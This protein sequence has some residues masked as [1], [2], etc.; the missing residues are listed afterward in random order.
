M[1]LGPAG[2]GGVSMVLGSDLLT[3]RFKTHATE[4]VAS[5]HL[6]EASKPITH[7]EA[8]DL[9]L[10]A[11]L[12]G[13]SALAVCL[14]SG[15]KMVGYDLVKTEDVLSLA[16]GS[17]SSDV[18]LSAKDVEVGALSLLRF[19]QDSCVR[20]GSYLL[21]R[22]GG[23]D[24]T[25]RLF[26]LSGSTLSPGKLEFMA[27]SAANA[28]SSSRAPTGTT[29]EASSAASA[30]L[31]HLLAAPEAWAVNLAT[32]ALEYAQVVLG[33]AQSLQQESTIVLTTKEEAPANV[34]PKTTSSQRIHLLLLRRRLLQESID[35]MTTQDKNATFVD[36]LD[37][38]NPR[39]SS[40]STK[41]SQLLCA[42]HCQI[43]SAYLSIADELELDTTDVPSSVFEGMST[44]AKESSSSSSD[45]DSLRD[46][47]RIHVLTALNEAAK[48]LVLS[49]R[50]NRLQNDTVM[51]ATNDTLP[52]LYPDEKVL[53]IDLSSAAHRIVS[54]LLSEHEPINRAAA[55]MQDAELAF[56][57]IE[58]ILRLHHERHDSITE[59]PSI[60][61]SL[62]A[63]MLG[64]TVYWITRI[65]LSASASHTPIVSDSLVAS[66][67]ALS[68][69]GKPHSQAFVIQLHDQSLR[70]NKAMNSLSAQL[71]LKA[72]LLDFAM[73]R[74][75]GS[76][77]TSTQLS[78]V[79]LLLYDASSLLSQASS[80]LSPSPSSSSLSASS[81]K[82]A[83]H[84]IKEGSLT[85]NLLRE[86]K[87]RLGNEL[88]S[89]GRTHVS[90][91]SLPAA[92][93]CFSRAV[94]VFDDVR[95]LTNKSIAMTNVSS[96]L[97]TLGA[98]GAR[99]NTATVLIE[100]EDTERDESCQFSLYRNASSLANAF[101]DG[102]EERIIESSKPI[103]ERV[104]KMTLTTLTPTTM[105]NE[106][107]ETIVSTS[108]TP[109]SATLLQKAL[110]VAI[111]AL[112]MAKEAVRAAKGDSLAT[113]AST[114]AFEMALHGTSQSALVF[115]ALLSQEMRVVSPP[116]LS[117]E[118]LTPVSLNDYSLALFNLASK[119]ISQS[120][121]G[122]LL[123][124]LAS[125]KLQLSLHLTRLARLLHQ[126][127]PQSENFTETRS[128]ALSALSDAASA[129]LKCSE[130]SDRAFSCHCYVEKAK[131]LC[132]LKGQ[133][134]EDEEKIFHR[135]KLAVCAILSCSLPL[136]SVVSFTNKKDLSDIYESVLQAASLAIRLTL[137]AL[138]KSKK[139][140]SDA[141]K[142]CTALYSECLRLIG[143]SSSSS[144]TTTTQSRTVSL[145]L[146]RMKE[147]EWL[148]K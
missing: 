90:S 140:Q 139:D 132:E 53:F 44:T 37:S 109:Q 31:K 16:R 12:G 81:E 3:V 15:G 26:D 108:I 17:G 124:P 40:S 123:K 145:V 38:R 88:V 76:S 28:T 93:A 39:L 19:L 85:F 4:E 83:T 27:S 49:I 79:C 69:S 78:H 10:D 103:E 105:S 62:I 143:G 41:Y 142:R 58:D 8:L 22:S 64:N 2:G 102:L 80:S 72:T 115:G 117:S 101:K 144:S 133:I 74:L 46:A 126:K 25:L 56:T 9:Y 110:D 89:A 84:Q 87:R 92:I 75:C 99:H 121:H 6:R 106:I 65:F 66:A 104:A 114:A 94:D 14:H 35:I 20:D 96:V 77:T 54:L 71:S 146:E 116:P 141:V 30:L 48:N 51:G 73:G 125:I 34:T 50:L 98:S 107:S 61:S 32:I 55:P 86:A 63:S 52:S 57:V 95:D 130:P 68:F 42:L 134:D 137:S 7:A 23:E 21:Y 82:R 60:A 97:R 122:A 120:S 59:F 43:A 13:A 127:W 129:F 148:Y 147:E 131:L 36:R 91:A 11:R 100:G 136:S 47:K 112:R 33:K 1:Q 118:R 18:E 111:D 45:S 29:E 70:D 119:A 24:T 135:L 128:S 67:S 138:K 113:E 5:V